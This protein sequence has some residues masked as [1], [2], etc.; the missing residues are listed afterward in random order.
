[1]AGTGELYK[2]DSGKWAFRVK[3]SNGDTVAVNDGGGYPSKTTAGTILKKLLHGGYD[4]PIHQAA[5]VV[6][7]QEITTNTTLDGN[8]V[9]ENGPAII[10]AAD[11]I[12]LDLAGFTISGKGPAAAEGPGILFRNV[13]GSTVQKGTVTHFGAGVAVTGG[14]ANVVQNVTVADNVGPADGDFGDGIVIT[15]ST[16]NV[17]QGNTVQRNGPYSGISVVGASTGNDIRQNVVTDNNMLPGDPGA[18]RQDMG[19]R[20][21]GPAANSNK[22]TGN[23]VTGS[24]ADGIVVLATCAD[25]NVGCAG[26]PPNEQNEITANMSHNNGTSG[27]GDGIRLFAVPQPVAPAHNTVADN[28]ADNNASNGVAIDANGAANPGPPEN[29][30]TGN[31]GHGN[32]QFD[33]FDGNT[34]PACGTNTW[35]GNDF[36]TFNQPCVAAGAPAPPAPPA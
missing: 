9:C 32:G 6:C 16:D 31:S 1:M 28:V 13:T 11:N 30:V 19:I 7:G 20:I 18:G 4:G 26:T 2:N 34:A 29:T 27:R 35:S 25:P 33:G 5:A 21:E 3:A 14:S 23:T 22:I 24:G 8:L 12:T 17:I 15:D 10:I 36:G